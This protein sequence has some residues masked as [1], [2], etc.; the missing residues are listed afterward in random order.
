ME[1]NAKIIL[2][3]CGKGSGMIT[4]V[5]MRPDWDFY[6]LW[7]MPPKTLSEELSVLIEPVF[8]VDHEME[9]GNVVLVFVFD[10][11][12]DNIIQWRI[13]LYCMREFIREGMKRMYKQ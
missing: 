8:A 12:G 1:E 5:E 10:G 13:I 7:D 9:D 3:G 2:R 11:E 4:E 6:N